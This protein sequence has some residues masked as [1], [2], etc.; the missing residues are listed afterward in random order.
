MSLVNPILAALGVAFV[1]LPILLHFLR[2]RRPPVAWGA[3]RFLLEAYR[4]QRRRMTLEQILLL[5]SRCLLVLLLAGLLG[6]PFF[7]SRAD[8]AGPREVY[9]LLDNSI[10][11]SVVRDGETTLDGFKAEAERLLSDLD[12]SRGDSA[13]LVLLGG[14][15]EDA[16]LPPSADI[17][18]VLRAVER[19]QATQSRADIPGAIDLVARSLGN[20]AEGAAAS[21]VLL[22]EFLAGSVPSESQLS[23]LPARVNRIVLREPRD[24]PEAENIAV[25]SLEPLRGVAL[26]ARGAGGQATVWLERSG[27]GID[28]AKEAAVR[29]R[30]EPGGEVG[31]AVAR[32]D[33][34]ARQ[35]SALVSFDLPPA[36]DGRATVLTA[37][38]D[39]DALVA[40]D[41]ASRPLERRAALRVGIVAQRSGLGRTGVDRFQPADWV[42]LA[43][44]PA[45]DS[46]EIDLVDF[47]PAGLDRPS[48]SSLDA[49]ILLEPDALP[50][51]AWPL[52]RE[53]TDRGGLLIVTPSHRPGAQLW[54]DALA[55]AMGVAWTID[56]EPTDVEGIGIDPASRE[57]GDRL[58]AVI[59]GELE[60]LLAGVTVDRLLRVDDNTT[61]ASRVLRTA[62]GDSLLIAAQPG[63]AES[64]P[65][66]G[67]IVY[68][69]VAPTPEWTDLPT[70]PAMVPIMQ[71]IVRQGVGVSRGSS[72]V[73]AGGAADFGGELVDDA[74]MP[75]RMP[76]RFAGVFEHR[77][78]RGVSLGPV[79]VNPDASGSRL[80]PISRE[81]LLEW[82]RPASVEGRLAWL[83]DSGRVELVGGGVV[84]R[85]EHA[86]RRMVLLLASGALLFALIETLLARAVSRGADARTRDAGVVA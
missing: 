80:D 24:G 61:E 38:V 7:G 30:A 4:R 14:P 16:V 21:V 35:T 47:A 43:L 5:A 48:L 66:A 2:R 32:F 13:A 68:L 84:R 79:A 29:L 9:L 62:S 27:S 11:A 1:A 78:A 72:T 59:A 85:D 71:E 23:V 49:L 54:P 40:D 37:S 70:R 63:G 41:S 81:R 73:I 17:A 82:L 51:S 33:P 12:P 52:L 45:D 26:G 10:A 25:T 36:M 19:V 34:G 86:G 55:G 50:D 6:R 58:L 46:G 57:T 69:A 64:T 8:D 75:V 53:M 15:A 42:R 56:R 74:G 18:G 60:S 44:S 20:E 77:D 83:D 3:M 67:L 65:S 31:R 28:R 39:A 22:S 76:I